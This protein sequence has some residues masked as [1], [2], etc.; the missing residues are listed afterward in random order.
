MTGKDPN[1]NYKVSGKVSV[2]V[3][4][5]RPTDYEALFEAFQAVYKDVEL[6]IRYFSDGDKSLNYILKQASINKLPDVVFDDAASVP[7]YVAQGLAY[8]LDKFVK[9]VDLDSFEYSF[10]GEGEEEKDQTPPPPVPD[11]PLDSEPII[12]G[13]TP[14]LTEYDNYVEIINQ[15]LS[16]FEGEDIPEDLRKIIEEYLKMLK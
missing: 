1:A 2:A 16:S 4:T 11:E 12:D 15:I 13:E 14:Y 9:D 10:E 7:T 8:P 3:N 5:N 6:E